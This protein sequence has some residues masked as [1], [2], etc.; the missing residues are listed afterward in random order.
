MGDTTGIAWTSHTWNP[1]MGCFKVSQG[2]KNCYADVLTSGKM[3]LDVFGSD[4]SKRQKTGKSVWARPWLWNR[5]AAGVGVPARTFCASLADV[6]EDAPGPNEWRKDV[7]TVIRET[8]W[9]DWQLLTKRPENLERMLPD[10]WGDGWGNVW[11]GTSIEDNVVAE[12]SSILTSVPAFN[13]F[14]SYEPAIGPGD[15]IPLE[16][17]EWMIVGGESGPGYRHMDLQWAR[18]MRVRCADSGVAFFF[19]QDSAIRT[20]MGIDALGE[21]VRHYP[22]SW[23]R[24]SKELKV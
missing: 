24:L 2:C 20:E 17:V 5:D 8:T 16:G 9:L 11:L 4:L 14:I 3:G 21:V 13:H 23:N 1:W 6:F 10:D 19:K 7:F 12:R 15:E 18:D 22:K